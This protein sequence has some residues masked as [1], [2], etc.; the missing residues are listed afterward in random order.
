M[1]AAG[2]ITVSPPSE[3]VKLGG[4]KQYSAMVSGLSPTTV[5]WSVKG[6][7][8][9]DMTGLYTAPPVGSIATPASV[10]IQATSMAYPTV[11]GTAALQLRA[12][13][14]TITSVT[15]NNFPVGKFTLTISGSGFQSGAQAYIPNQY[16]ATTFVS[17]TQLTVSGSL[18]SVGSTLIEVMN[19]GSM[20]SNY[21]GITT[22]Y[23][24]G[25]SMLAVAPPAAAVPAGL[26]QQFSATI[27]NAPAAVGWSVSG[28]AAY[29]TITAS[30]LY[31]APAQIPNPPT[32]T[33]TASGPNSTTAAATVTILSNQPPA[34]SSVS[35][36]PMPLGVATLTLTGNGFANGSVVSVGGAPVATQFSN[37]QLM[38]SAFSGTGASTTVTVSNGPLVSGPF[39]LPVGVP[40]ALVSAGAARRFLEQAAFG[41]TPADA[42][43]VQQVGFAGWLNEQ[44]AGPKVSNYSG[45]GNQSGMGT[46]FLTNAVSNPDQLRQKVAFAYSQIFVTSLNKNIWTSITAPYEEMLM[47]DAFANYRQILNDVT[48]APAMGQFLD[49]ANNAKGN[50]AGTILPNE[51]YAREVLQLFSIGTTWLNQDGSQQLDVQGN[52]IP[53]YTQPTITQFARVFTGWTYAP[54][55]PSTT[56]VWNSY[57]N[58][59]TSPMVPYQ[60][61]H[62]TAAKVLLQGVLAP[63][64]INLSPGQTA[65]QDLNDALD[66]IFYHP[67]VAPFIS[68]QLI[69]HLVKSNPSPNYISHV[70]AVF[71]NNGQGVRGDM[72][73]VI[74]AILADP[75]ARANDAGGFDQPAD[76]HMQEPALFIAGVVRALG[77]QMNDQNYFA[78]D[79]TNM[80]EDI[81]NA[82]SVFNYYSP[83][84]RVPGFGIGGPEFQIYTA[85]TSVYRANLLAGLF[86]SYSNP[87]QTNGPGTTID[88]TPYVNLAATP[89]LL[90]SA[91]DLALT[92][93]QMP[94][95]MKQIVTTAV[96]NESGGNLRRVQTAIY[97][98]AGSGYYNVWH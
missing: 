63:G 2:T 68:R 73:A 82:P 4:S 13:G 15:P 83:G 93:G 89:G 23:S 75:E 60:P 16:F 25:G 81:Y 42:A 77:G 47:T 54:V 5:L 35:P 3:S 66:N 87:I 84:Y 24:G 94:A 33:I 97:L 98:I 91:V 11:M 76:G 43:H 8:S 31:T 57:I 49:M 59:T 64:K 92:H 86:G 40:N 79:L 67:N 65:Q 6:P 58:N 34:I 17:P 30:G 80:G 55:P 96:Q 78:W 10:T 71:N 52:P 12:P 39:T 48:L 90:V 44:F 14:P 85:A 51:N 74:T 20:F 28:G 61:M 46:R 72:K 50:A 53:T 56:V 88:L 9:I 7:G 41:P 21:L 62:D 95:A 70:A 29:G 27:N 32:A 26:T 37:G 38:V 18:S 19:P 1:Q 69:Q 22:T 45:I 36:N